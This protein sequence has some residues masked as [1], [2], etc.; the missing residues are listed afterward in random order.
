M[1]KAFWGMVAGCTLIFGILLGMY[2]NK[3]GAVDFLS[4][5]PPAL[6][7]Q[8]HNFPESPEEEK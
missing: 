3:S 5:P 2:L 4:V 6:S 1:E 8:L 7:L